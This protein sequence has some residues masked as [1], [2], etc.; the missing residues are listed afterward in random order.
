MLFPLLWMISTSLKAPG[1]EYIMPPSLIPDPVHWRNYLE[2][3]RAMPFGRFLFNTCLVTV[4]VT[5]GQALTCSMAAFAFSRL[6]FPG[7]DKIFLLYLTTLMIPGVVTLI[8]LFV[9]MQYFGWIDTYQA[10]II[11][12]LFSAYGTFLL[13]Q[14]FLG[15]PL[16]L[17]DSAH[18]DGCG[19][20][21]VYWNVI[22]PLSKPALV[23]LIIFTFMGAWRDF[24][25]PLVITNSL[26][27][28]T[29]TVGLSIFRGAYVS[30]WNLMMAGSCLVMAPLV[31]VFLFNQRFFVEGIQLT[32]IKG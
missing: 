27:M 5:F 18:I 11:P 31:F 4:A 2:V 12:G 28:R 30:D 8:P 6:K 3:F 15:I 17:E 21:G 20:W 9:I 24:L 22:L 1:K 25:W 19:P 26:E 23:T 16:A 14:F 7:R 32:G 13:R 29:L 10:L